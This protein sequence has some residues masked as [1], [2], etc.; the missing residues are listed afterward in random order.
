MT[1][2]FMLLFIISTSGSFTCHDLPALL[3]LRYVFV[4]GE[5]LFLDQNHT[6]SA[7]LI[8]ITELFTR[9]DNYITSIDICHQTLY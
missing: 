5:S 4:V 7:S 6:G 8:A 1:T 2:Y 3:A 9:N